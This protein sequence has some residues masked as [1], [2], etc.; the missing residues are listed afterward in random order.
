MKIT[1]WRIANKKYKNDA[2]SGEGAKLYGGRWNPIGLP[3]VYT[4]QNLS[5]AI[6]E[7]IVHLED[8]TDVARYVTIPV[9]FNNSQAGLLQKKNLPKDWNRLPIPDSTQ[10]AG[11]KWMLSNKTLLLKVPSSVVPLEYNYLINPLHPDFSTL[12]IGKAQPISMDSRIIE[13]IK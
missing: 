9:S 13:K 8:E 4:A 10:L 6:L 11:K 12:I 2:F 1:A 3:M 5:L 7:L